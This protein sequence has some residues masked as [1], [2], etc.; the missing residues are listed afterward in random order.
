[1]DLKRLDQRIS[2][3]VLT[4]NRADELTTTLE[5]LL[6]LPENP[7]IVVADNGSSDGT[8]ALVRKRFPMVRVIECGGNL[9]A[10]GRNRAV[11]CVRTDYVAF[12]DDDTWWAP[13]SLEHAVQLLDAWPTVGVLSA[14]VAVGDDETTDPTCA[15]MRA[16]PLGS[17][18]LPG[19]ALIGYMAGA[20][21]FRTSLF[22]AVGGYEP[23]LFIGGE[24]ELVALDVLAA[25][26]S[27]VYCEQMTVHHH[28]SAVRDSGLRRR[29][30]ARNAAWIAWLRLPWPQA[31][32]A[33]LRALAALTREGSFVHDSVALLHGLMWALPRRRV[34]PPAV[35]SLRERVHAVEQS[36]GEMSAKD[37]AEA[38]VGETEART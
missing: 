18:G 6:A 26:H 12:C 20:C 16:S 3:V 30:L 11:A 29:M 25:N 10:A 2:V 15:A 5:H 35:L 28:P 33:T 17:D 37:R 14:R 1:M 19:P 38:V 8:V 9:G 36:T 31:C 7:P 22:R 21:V 34:V 27:I 24:E 4:C 23:R 13:G 32:R